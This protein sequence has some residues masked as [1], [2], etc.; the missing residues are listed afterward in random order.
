MRYTLKTNTDCRRAG[1]APLAAVLMV[2]LL[3]MM[4]FSVD[5][6]YITNS[7]GELQSAADAA[8]LA[9]AQQLEKPYF[10]WRAASTSTLKSTIRT[11][12]ISS[13]KSAAKTIAAA[14]RAGGVNVTLND[15]DITVGYLDDSGN[16]NASPD[17]TI[18][19]NSVLV[20]TR[21]DSNANGEVGLFFGPVI[22]M[23]T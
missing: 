8:S 16:W 15:S 21:R 4:A 14:N 7:K 17:D 22:G 10:L 23:S 11:D 5:L 2:P 3:A 13:A 20:T 1:I 19:P 6:A 12:A 9:G 18:W